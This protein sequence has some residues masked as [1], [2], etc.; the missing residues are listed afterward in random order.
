MFENLDSIDW[1][2]F[3]TH[4]AVGRQSKDIPIYIRGLISDDEEERVRNIQE[5]FGEG[6]H[7]GMHGNATPYIIPFAIEVLALETYPEKSFLLMALEYSC[8]HMKYAQTISQM[9][10]NVAIYDEIEK[11]LPIFSQ[12]LGDSNAEVRLQTVELL[13]YMQDKIDLVLKLLKE[14]YEIETNVKVRTAILESIC[15]LIF[16]TGSQYHPKI[17]P[18]ISFLS[19]IVKQ[20]KEFS[21]RV[22]VSSSLLKLWRFELDEDLVRTISETLFQAFIEADT[23]YVKTSLAKHISELDYETIKSFLDQTL[24]AIETHLLIKAMLCSYFAAFNKSSSNEYW[25]HKSK[26]TEVGIFYSPRFTNYNFELYQKDVLLVILNNDKF[27]ELPS[28]LLSLLFGLPD[29]RVDLQNYLNNM[30]KVKPVSDK[31]IKF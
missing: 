31:P 22:I 25:G 11:G 27:W 6:Q 28:N 16:E 30:D 3:G 5:L 1:A 13:R 7:F 4:I 14:N 17:K 18:Y 8:H 23:E 20:G 9:R 12:L 15:E 24:S 29:K 26:L 19:N 21:G 10:F 2:S